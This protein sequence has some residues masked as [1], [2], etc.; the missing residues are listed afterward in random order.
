MG[1]V[2]NVAL[3]GTM[4]ALRVA[5]SP[6]AGSLRAAPRVAAGA[7]WERGGVHAAAAARAVASCAEVSDSILVCFP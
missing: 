5:V 2:E 7:G 6:G 3:V 4:L 1:G